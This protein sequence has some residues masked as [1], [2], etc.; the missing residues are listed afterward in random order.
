LERAG[1]WLSEHRSYEEL[2]VVRGAWYEAIAATDEARA[3]MYYSEEL[4]RRVEDAPFVIDYLQSRLEELDKLAVEANQEPS[5]NDVADHLFSRAR[6]DIGSIIGSI[7]SARDGYELPAP[8]LTFSWKQKLEVA[9]ETLH[10]TAEDVRQERQMNP[11]DEEQREWVNKTI[12]SFN[13]RR[14]LPALVLC[15]RCGSQSVKKSGRRYWCQICGTRFAFGEGDESRT[16][17]GE[18]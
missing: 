4:G 3:L 7:K 1:R 9:S 6:L 17:D 12:E 10:R 2:Q 11:L 5:R 15:P 14:E 8:N 18:R 13:Q 16:A